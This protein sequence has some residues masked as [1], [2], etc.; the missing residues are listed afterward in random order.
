MKRRYNEIDV[1]ELTT[2]VKTTMS[3]I[4]IVYN[5][6]S[7]LES[8]LKET[9][10]VVI[11][12]ECNSVLRCI[13]VEKLPGAQA[14]GLS[15]LLHSAGIND[16][17]SILTAGVQKIAEIPGIDKTEAESICHEAKKL[18]E[19][20]C[21]ELVIPID[22][23]SVTPAF[24]ELITLIANYRY[25]TISKLLAN[26]MY[27]FLPENP[28]KELYNLEPI[29]SNLAWKQAKRHQK[30]LALDSY[31]SLLSIMDRIE[32]IGSPSI[33]SKDT[34]YNS[35]FA[36]NDFFTHYDVYFEILN[37]MLPNTFCLAEKINEKEVQRNLDLYKKISDTILSFPDNLADFYSYIFRA[38]QYVLQKNN[39]DNDVIMI[40]TDYITNEYTGLIVSIARYRFTKET[41]GIVQK[42]AELLPSDPCEI[43]SRVS[44][45]KSKDEWFHADRHAQ[46][47]AQITY[48]ELKHALIQVVKIGESESL[49]KKW[50]V[51]KA[52]AWE[53]FFTHSS[54]Y[55]TLLNKLAPNLFSPA[56]HI[57]N[58]DIQG[59][60]RNCRQ[61]AKR[62]KDYKEASSEE[63]ISKFANVVLK[64]IH[65]AKMKSLPIDV[66]K[67]K[68][69]SFRP[70]S[71]HI[72]GLYN[73]YDVLN[74]DMENIWKHSRISITDAMSVSRKVKDISEDIMKG[75]RIQ[76]SIDNITPA[77]TDL[78]TSIAKYRRMKEA[79][80]ILHRM[81][82]LM[83]TNLEKQ[84][85]ALTPLSSE[86]DW[87]NSTIYQQKQS[88]E[89]YYNLERAVVEIR[90]I[91]ISSNLS[92]ILK[93][94][95]DT[96]W[97][98]YA[99]HPIEYS[100]ILEEVC[101]EQ[102][103]QSE[104]GYGLEVELRDNVKQIRLDLNGLNCSL[105]GYQVWGVK[106]ILQQK[107]VLLGD[108]MG[109]GKTIQALAAMV[110]MRNSGAQHFLVVCPASVIEN[111][112]REIEFKSDMTAYNLHGRRWGNLQKWI[113]NGGVAVINY[114]IIDFIISYGKRV[115]LDMCVVDEAHYIKNP[116]A[117][118]T[119][120]VL[121]VCKKTDRVLFMTGTPI[122]NRVDEMIGLMRNL[123]P[124]VADYALKLASI[125]S[126]EEFK[127]KITS[128]YYR[129]K[130]EDVLSELP[131]LI[132]SKEWCHMTTEDQIAYENAMISESFQQ[133][134][135]VAWNHQHYLTRSSKV[136]RL[137]ELV[138]EASADQRK[139]IVFSF[140]RETLNQIQTIFQNH[141]VGIINGSVSTKERQQIIDSFEAAPAGTVLAAQI[142]AGGVGLN[143]Q[144]ASV[145]IICEPQWKPS[146]ENQAI[147]RAYRMGQTRDVLVYRLLCTDTID[148]EI[149]K[150]LT[151]KQ[152]EF[153]VFAD[154][155]IAGK[156]DLAQLETTVQI[157]PKEQKRLLIQERDR[158]LEKRMH[159]SEQKSTDT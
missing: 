5:R 92:N 135:R 18:Y 94:D 76:L 40:N 152:H 68:G 81:S 17:Y 61:T 119:S 29:R 131:D 129:R 97:K 137:K 121:S 13:A 80:P 115:P 98:D 67:D 154:E 26:K 90:N 136:Q 103:S 41:E 10:H 151:K 21:S 23:D 75:C 83:P 86:Q 138:K 19:K 3:A 143:I 8:R 82:D 27:A 77:Y 62:I 33:L 95:K 91:E 88:W 20:T 112:C 87:N 50:N 155:S 15:T 12:E 140:F 79:L 141:C 72:V 89:T 153:D 60:A 159:S 133:A 139:T 38:I 122:E 93:I 96:A 99:T 44:P 78:V 108:E 118:R 142:E 148:E 126:S 39:S 74:E 150:L 158:I 59:I 104:E 35:D 64:D 66:L 49:A 101:P 146:T 30:Q 56:E 57:T 58:E 45:M 47:Q 36:W 149:T 28:L 11:R 69:T 34:F 16:S 48:N 100:Q 7:S 9:L 37:S 120:Q 24:T 55:F 145:V 144:A 63:N 110:S 73:L 84:L 14:D 25:A 102:S 111:W 71:F 65:D 4:D 32:S 117:K 106:Y 43:L 22:T 42:M 130:R 156:R 125:Y 31:Q 116:D 6:V 109:L 1:Q 124:D 113:K 54:D 128:V 2:R 85:R 157:D 51:D 132:E 147:S 114:D 70:S 134:R 53:D 52:S 127:R 123:Q 46:R 105:R 107:K